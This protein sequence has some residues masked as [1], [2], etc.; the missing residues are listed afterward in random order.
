M[1]SPPRGSRRV[2][3]LPLGLVLLLGAGFV[4]CCSGLLLPMWN[5]QRSL[6]RRL[7]AD[8]KL[9]LPAGARVTHGERV[10]TMDPGEYYRLELPP[11][12]VPALISRMFGEQHPN[13][14]Q[15]WLERAP[16]WWKPQELPDLKRFDVHLFGR[17]Y[18]WFYSESSGTV[19]VFWYKT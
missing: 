15:P 4:S 7:S 1:D 16:E 14:R 2:A 19:Y 5:P 10:A 6:E 3:L 18:E 17:G 12:E 11:G 13:P 8:L 9:T